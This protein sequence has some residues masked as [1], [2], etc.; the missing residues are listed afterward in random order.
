MKLGNTDLEVSPLALGTWVFAGDQLWGKQN[1]L[2]SIRTI[3][4]ALDLGVNF[5]DTAPAYG[6]GKAEKR[7]GRALEG[8][9]SKAVI[10]SKI[11]QQHQ[12]KK[13]LIKSCE[14]SLKLL[15]TDFIDLMQI[16][17]P[18]PEVPTE[19]T[20]EALT[21]LKEQGKIRHFGV[22]NFGVPELEEWN[23]LGGELVSNQLPYSLL[24]RSIEYEIVPW[25]QKK[26]ISVLAYSPLMQGLL[27]GKFR[28]AD[29][30]PD[31]RARSRHFRSDRPLAR[32]GEEG[33]EMETFSAIEKVREI[34]HHMALPMSA[35]ALAWLIQ[36]LFVGSVL[37]GAR[38]VKQL[39]ENLFAANL[40]LPQ[41]TI[42]ELN[43]A[44][45]EVKAIL[46]KNPDMW[47]SPGRIG[48]GSAK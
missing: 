41:E 33:C 23:K 20:L 16:H 37:F 46:G 5:F 45:N 4:A 15:R 22:C 18:D 35:V 24:T 6:D 9:R 17:W 27:T 28:D 10:A 7:L 14:N 48:R 43:A 39:K 1:K 31:G 47:E 26:D 40:E 8:R 29:E 11:S 3:H 12:R 2:E 38:S 36:H 44:T 21:M 25:C 32:H 19:E 30:V 42:N 13:D 34:C